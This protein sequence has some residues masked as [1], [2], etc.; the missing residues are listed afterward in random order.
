MPLNHDHPDSPD[1]PGTCDTVTVMPLTGPYLPPP[2]PAAPLLALE[3][4][5]GARATTLACQLAR[6][7]ADLRGGTAVPTVVHLVP[8]FVRTWPAMATT[9]TRRPLPQLARHAAGLLDA[10]DTI[11]RHLQAGP[12]I[13]NRH[14]SSLL[15]CHAAASGATISQAQA[16]LAPVRG[17]LAIPTRTIYLMTSAQTL[18][19][20]LEAKT[21]LTPFSQG[22]LHVHGRLEQVQDHLAV[23]AAADQDSVVLD[24]DGQTPE[25]IAEEIIRTMQER[26]ADA[27]MAL[28][29]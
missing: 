5:P 14:L 8:D 10:S 13:A 18:R 21:D 23:L 29:T 3:A 20:R 1:P 9:G 17:Y 2:Q 16:V 24:A 7:L 11:R 27:D 15:V 6:Q 28:Q 12:V 4:V 26:P 19:R 25:E 22:L